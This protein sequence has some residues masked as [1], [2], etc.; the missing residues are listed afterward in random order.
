[1]YP[2]AGRCEW[3]KHIHGLS[4]VGFAQMSQLFCFVETVVHTLITFFIRSPYS[5]SVKCNINTGFDDSLETHAILWTNEKL[6]LSI[7]AISYSLGIQLTLHGR[8]FSGLYSGLQ[9]SCT[10]DKDII[11]TPR[12]KLSRRNILNL[13]SVVQEVTNSDFVVF[14]ATNLLQGI[15]VWELEEKG[16]IATTV[17]SVDKV[18]QQL[19]VWNSINDLPYTRMQSEVHDLKSSSIDITFDGIILNAKILYTEL[20]KE[21]ACSILIDGNTNSCSKICWTPIFRQQRRIEIGF[22]WAWDRVQCLC[23]FLHSAASTRLP[24]SISA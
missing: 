15:D 6:L 10:A 9:I 14:S 5:E 4:S 19:R 17:L 24:H 12:S 11:H 22:W 3:K 18:S 23:Q 21:V 1:M 16:G 13:H 8:L 20:R 2:S 7:A